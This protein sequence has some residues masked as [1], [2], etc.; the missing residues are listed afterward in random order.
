MHQFNSSILREYDVRGIVGKT[1]D[2]YDAFFLGKSFGTIVR[3]NGG[4]K[5][6]VGY[7]GRISSPD[8]EEKITE[9]I[10]STGVDVLRIGCGPSP[11]LYYSVFELDADGGI[12]ITGSHNPPDYN[13]FKFML[14]KSGFYGKQIKALGDVAATGDFEK[15]HGE[16]R[17]VNVF[18]RYADRLLRDVDFAAWERAD[19][20]VAWDPGNG[21][22]GEVVAALISRLPGKHYL[23][24]GE[25]DGTFP[26]HHPDPTVAKNLS[27]IKELIADK[28]MDMGVAFD[29]DG[30]RIGA[31]DGRGDI[32][33]GDQ[34]LA[35]FAEEILKSKPGSNIVADVKCSQML[36]DRVKELGGNPVMWKTGHSLIKSKMEETGAPIAGEMSAHIFIKD[37]YYGFDDAIYAAIRLI[38]IASMVEG[39]LTAL[40]RKLPNVVNTPEIRIDTN[41]ND[42]FEIVD[43]ILKHLKEHNIAYNDIDG[44]RV[45]TDDGWWLIRASNTQDVVVARCEG[46]DETALNALVS[47]L[48]CLLDRYGLKL[49][50]VL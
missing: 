47:E 46:K 15:G 33:W 23:I 29:G 43:D 5:I 41:G 4:K 42:P 49:P 48:Q 1:L 44:A 50:E 3:R 26:N 22:A 16:A 17:H 40:K 11:M 20:S 37:N 39:G 6:C 8:F 32:I 30:D 38:N 2:G 7:D 28:K 24:N 31:V 19:L 35:I 14:G 34:L 25:I 9:G 10:I 18:D 12:M 21:A 45:V 36:F 13:G 27:Q